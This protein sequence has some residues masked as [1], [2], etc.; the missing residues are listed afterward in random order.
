MVE[1]LSPALEHVVTGLIA[2]ESVIYINTSA[3]ANTI[4]N[5]VG[6][7]ALLVPA[8]NVT[9]SGVEESHAATASIVHETSRTSAA[10]VYSVGH[11]VVLAGTDVESTAASAAVSTLAHANAMAI[12]A[13]EG[14]MRT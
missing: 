6:N 9:V 11:E 10:V 5:A 1:L 4:V 7:A 2:E 3:A 8:A 12:C 14:A 13:A